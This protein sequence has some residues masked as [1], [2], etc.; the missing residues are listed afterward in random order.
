MEQWV[1]GLILLKKAFMPDDN[2]IT[3]KIS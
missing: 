3:A 2:R 1:F